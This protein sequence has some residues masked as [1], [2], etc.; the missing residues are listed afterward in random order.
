M[1]YAQEDYILEVLLAHFR[2]IILKASHRVCSATVK[3]YQLRIKEA[4]AIKEHNPDL[5]KQVIS[6]KT[7]LLL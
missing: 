7:K 6:Y 4:L 2:A 5:N 3:R 1:D